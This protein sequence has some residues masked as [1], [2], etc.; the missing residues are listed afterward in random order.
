M[1]E[2]FIFIIHTKMIIKPH[3]KTDGMSELKKINIKTYKRC[4]IDSSC[5]CWANDWAVIYN[6]KKILLGYNII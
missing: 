6:K 3:T 5:R 4:G 1:C 2:G